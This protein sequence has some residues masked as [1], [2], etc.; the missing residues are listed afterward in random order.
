MKNITHLKNNSWWSKLQNNKYWLKV[1]L[2]FAEKIIFDIRLAQLFLT[3]LAILDAC[4]ETS[5]LL[6]FLEQRE[7]KMYR[8]RLRH[9]AFKT[10]GSPKKAHLLYIPAIV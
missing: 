9:S 7:R 3:E 8:S 4:F 1:C 10:R 5:I 2:T 6:N